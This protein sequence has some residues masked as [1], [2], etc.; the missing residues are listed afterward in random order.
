M[1][2]AFTSAASEHIGLFA[3]V[4]QADSLNLDISEESADAQHVLGL[5]PQLPDRVVMR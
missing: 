4:L 3:H 2:N 1:A 5:V